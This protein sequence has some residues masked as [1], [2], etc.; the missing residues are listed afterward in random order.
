M[1]LETKKTVALNDGFL[2]L[3]NAGIKNTY[4]PLSIFHIF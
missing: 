2:F 4:F 1:E 3:K